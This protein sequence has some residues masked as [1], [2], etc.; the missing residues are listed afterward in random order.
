MNQ[1]LNIKKL[2]ANGALPL[3]LGFNGAYFDFDVIGGP[4]DVYKPGVNG[5]V[6]ICVREER[7]PKTADFIL[8][9]RDFSVPKDPRLVNHVLERAIDALLD[10]K[11][12]Y[13][14]CMGGW[15]RT[16]LFLAVL[17]KAAGCE[18]PVAYVRE[19]YTARAVETDEQQE[20]VSKF[21]VSAIR[22]YLFWAAWKKRWLNTLFWWR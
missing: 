13:V 4:F 12:V 10:G 8:P 19:K 2:G 15:G 16:G 3:R 20:Y 9:V 11:R 14:G 17:A 21:D 22:S 7:A 6:G 1:G 18:D 5:D